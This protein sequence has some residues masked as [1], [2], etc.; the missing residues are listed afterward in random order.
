MTPQQ[1]KSTMKPHQLRRALHRK[2][3][4][5]PLCESYT[6]ECG[7]VIEILFDL[8]RYVECSDCG[9]TWYERYTLADAKVID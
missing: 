4:Q 1:K 7:P 6:F 2:P 9:G 3:D 5:C 8:A